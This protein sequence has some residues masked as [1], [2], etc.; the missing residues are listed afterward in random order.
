MTESS[1]DTKADLFLV[2]YVSPKEQLR[3]EDSSGLA[4]LFLELKT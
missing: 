3:L 1:R 4:E 2:Q